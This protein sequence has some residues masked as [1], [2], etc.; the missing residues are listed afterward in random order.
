MKNMLCHFYYLAYIVHEG[1]VLPLS[2]HLSWLPQHFG[3]PL[4]LYSSVNSVD[5]ANTCNYFDKTI[6][7][8]RLKAHGKDESLY[9]FSPLTQY[10]YENMKYMIFIDI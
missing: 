10:T 6:P 1:Q 4:P 7:L 9:M 8:S 5:S 2:D 3:W